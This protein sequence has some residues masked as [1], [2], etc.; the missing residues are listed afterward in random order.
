MMKIIADPH[1]RRR[2]LLNGSLERRMLIEHAHYSQPRAVARARHTDAPVIIWD[3]FEQP[4]DRVVR[5]GAFIDS[6]LV[7]R[8]ARLPE[9]DEL[10]LGLEPPA[11][12][13]R[14]DD[15]AVGR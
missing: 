12:I 8:I 1:I 14:D 6:V 9:H 2:G 4:I 5:V 11:N 15:V 7:L 10:P 13:L 3:I